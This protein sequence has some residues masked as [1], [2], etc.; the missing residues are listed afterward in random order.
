MIQDQYFPLALRSVASAAA[1]SNPIFAEEGLGASS[2][3]SEGTGIA[4]VAQDLV[5]PA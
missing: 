3:E 5:N 2:A 1:A 4:R